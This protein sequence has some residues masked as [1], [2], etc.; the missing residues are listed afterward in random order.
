MGASRGPV[1][2]VLAES[3]WGLEVCARALQSTESSQRVVLHGVSVPAWATPVEP[4]APDRHAS[5]SRIVLCLLDILR[6]CGDFGQKRSCI[7]R[8]A[9]YRAIP[10]QAG[11]MNETGQSTAY[12]R[13]TQG[14]APE[15]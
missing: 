13:A 8:R 2:K 6:P 4:F 9:P 10:G 11:H 1:G 14:R 12:A 15:P 7:V 3:C 5:S